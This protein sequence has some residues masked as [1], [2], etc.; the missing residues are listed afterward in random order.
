[1]T[2]QTMPVG[3]SVYL[4]GG[5]TNVLAVEASEGNATAADDFVSSPALPLVLN[6]TVVYDTYSESSRQLA[7]M[8][9]PR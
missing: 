7:G 6:A 3:T 4:L 9:Q 2:L 1:M 8:P 5:L